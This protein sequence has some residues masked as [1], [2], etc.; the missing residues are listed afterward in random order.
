LLQ[1]LIRPGLDRIEGVSPSRI[2]PEKASELAVAFSDL[3]SLFPEKESVVIDVTQ[4]DRLVLTPEKSP[5]NP[6]IL[7]DILEE[8]LIPRERLEISP[9][10]GQITLHFS[11]LKT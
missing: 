1:A 4:E 2:S 3:F 5:R 9:E 11:E 6:A 10:A 8:L 7:E